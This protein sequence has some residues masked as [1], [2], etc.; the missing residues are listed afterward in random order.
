MP[1]TEGLWETSYSLPGFHTCKEFKN[2]KAEVPFLFTR[3]FRDNRYM[4]T[5]LEFHQ[6]NINTVESTQI[7]TAV[8]EVVS[9]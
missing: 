8:W 9:L 7:G 4:V 2:N 1:V 5:F 3:N 6:E